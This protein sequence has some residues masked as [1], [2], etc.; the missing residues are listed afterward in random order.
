MATMREA[1]DAA[2]EATKGQPAEVQAAAV[3]AAIAPPTGEAVNWLWKALVI[4]L[5]AVLLLSLAGVVWAVID[6]K[7]ATSPDVLVTL[8]TATLTGLIGLFVKSP[9]QG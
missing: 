2:L 4:G 5:V 8:F 6:G 9:V 1:V 3:R 7:P